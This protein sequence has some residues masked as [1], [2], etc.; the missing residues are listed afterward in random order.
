MIKGGMDQSGSGLCPT[1][2]CVGGVGN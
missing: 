1:D 2:F